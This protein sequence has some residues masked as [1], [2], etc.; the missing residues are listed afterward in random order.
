M[1]TSEY[2]QSMAA[3]DLTWTP[4]I[5]GA[6]RLSA[7]RD[8]DRQALNCATVSARTAVYSIDPLRDPRWAE[9]SEKHARA[10][11]FHTPRWLEAL[12]RTYGY[13][14]VAYTTAPP[15]TALTNGVVVCRV[16]SLLTGRRLVSLPFSDHCEPLTDG[17]EDLESLLHFLECKRIEEGWK[18]IEIRPRTY[19]AVPPL[20]MVP[21]LTYSLH[22][23]DLGP[24]PA[25]IFRRFHKGSTQR[26]IRR[27]ERERL[28]YEEGRGEAFLEKFYA[29][30]LLTRRRQR[31]PPHP[32]A[33]FRNLMECLGDNAKIR[34]ASKDGR[35]IA[36]ILTLSRKD[37]MV[38]KY[39]CSDERFHNLG[40]MHLLLWTAI[41]EAK[42][43]GCREF[44]LGRSDS[45]NPG[46]ITFKD[47]WGSTRS[48]L[49]Y[50][51]NPAPLVP[52]PITAVTRRLVKFASAH[53]PNK[54]LIAAGDIFYKHIG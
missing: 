47:R 31:L 6:T 49:T 46:L 28:T 2:A 16:C 42:K 39:G 29:L 48:Q 51:R 21:A 44:D 12:R 50:W 11:V 52:L 3:V 4:P 37:V 18:Y 1:A 26:K 33:W 54:L 45:D 8:V 5:T 22:T 35:P 14:P 9:I 36:S 25:Q 10:S 40:G 41:Q 23:I 38:Y 53:V 24:E 7:S 15:G 19:S 17:P 34:V 13:E 20:M 43:A 27:A 30:L 32:R